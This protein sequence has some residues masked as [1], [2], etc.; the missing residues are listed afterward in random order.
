MNLLAGDR[1]G[2]RARAGRNHRLALGLRPKR[3]HRIALQ[4]AD[5][6]RGNIAN[7]AP[8]RIQPTAARVGIG[9][10]FG[11]FVRQ[12]DRGLLQRGERLRGKTAARL[13][14]RAPMIRE[15]IADAPRGGD[16]IAT[17]QRDRQSRIA[18]PESPDGY[19]GL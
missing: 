9:D 6:S 11:D 8:V 17:R 4:E 18:N 13:S 2:H 1:Q 12:H 3:L 14:L 16:V 5:L 10:S 15:R 7:L 19:S